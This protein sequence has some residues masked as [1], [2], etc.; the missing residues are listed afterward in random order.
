MGV[1]REQSKHKRKSLNCGK[2]LQFADQISFKLLINLPCVELG[3][4]FFAT[5]NTILW[6]GRVSGERETKFRGLKRDK[7]VFSSTHCFQNLMKLWNERKPLCLVGRIWNF[8]E[9]EIYFSF[10]KIFNFRTQ[11]PAGNLVR[12][13]SPSSSANRNLNSSLS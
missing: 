10:D 12:V 2:V 5:G 7:E 1:E 11:S 9:I 6:C 4:V 8:R 13:S 3:D